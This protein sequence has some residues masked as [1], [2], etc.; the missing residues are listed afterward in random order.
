MEL[1]WS[2]THHETRSRRWLRG[3]RV[4]RVNLRVSLLL[5]RRLLRRI[6]GSFQTVDGI[7]ASLQRRRVITFYRRR[8]EERGAGGG[9]GARIVILPPT[10]YFAGDA[11]TMRV[12]IVRRYLKRKEGNSYV[13]YFGASYDCTCVVLLLCWNTARRWQSARLLAVCSFFLS[14]FFFSFDWAL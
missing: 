4:G 3:S 8:W 7:R 11:Q 6:T 12:G 13:Q 9:I 1:D 14:L 5:D 2:I 10:I